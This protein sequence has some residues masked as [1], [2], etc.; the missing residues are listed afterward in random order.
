MIV[1]ILAMQPVHGAL[2]SVNYTAVWGR[3]WSNSLC[4][5]R[6]W[7]NEPKCECLEHLHRRRTRA[8]LR[9][10]SRSYRAV[11]ALQRSYL[12]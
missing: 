2:T 12:T 4:C 6:L 11:P 9:A 7:L 10:Y 5:P 8:L 1:F 3:K